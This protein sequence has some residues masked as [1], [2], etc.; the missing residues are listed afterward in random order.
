MNDPVPRQTAPE[1]VFGLVAPIGIDLDMVSDALDQTLKGMGYRAQ[2]FRLTDLMK[3]VPVPIAIENRS[4]V[5][6][7]RSRIAYANEVCHRLGNDG[8]A[9][10][11]ISAI[12]AFRSQERK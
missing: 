10:M 11:A 2:K 1:L 3:E 6:S 4:Y 7:Y 8:L 5:D 12:R 9:V